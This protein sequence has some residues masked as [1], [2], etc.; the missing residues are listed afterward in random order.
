MVIEHF[1][2]FCFLQGSM[3]FLP[4]L[5][6]NVCNYGWHTPCKMRGGLTPVCQ[7]LQQFIFSAYTKYLVVSL[8]RVHRDGEQTGVDKNNVALRGCVLKNTQYITGLV[9]YAGEDIFFFVIT[10]YCETKIRL[11]Q[12]ITGSM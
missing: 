12:H 7:P 1:S 8:F 6:V 4:I 5:Y 9:V 3:S 11:R 10:C 2:I